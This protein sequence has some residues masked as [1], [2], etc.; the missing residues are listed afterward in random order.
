MNCVKYIGLVF[1]LAQGYITAN[2]ISVRPWGTYEVLSDAADHKVKRIVVFPGKRLSLQRHT[3]RAEHWF[4]VKGAG[5]ATVGSEL[6][7]VQSGDTVDIAQ[8][9]L[10][11]I[12]NTG[13]EE[14]VFIEVQTGSYFGE[15]DIE[16]LEDDFGRI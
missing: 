4:I 14:L 6:R 10:H 15:D 11:R 13:N 9:M 1:L 7:D 16:R 8:R 3:Y 12:H 5:V 2:E